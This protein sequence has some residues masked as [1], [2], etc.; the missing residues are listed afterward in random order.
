MQQTRSHASG[1]YRGALTMR[2]SDVGPPVDEE[3]S[4]MDVLPAEE[5]KV[6]RLL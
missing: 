1:S 4:D 5:R 2:L 6:D 3:T